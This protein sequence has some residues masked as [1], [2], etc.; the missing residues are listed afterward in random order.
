MSET[1]PAE[2]MIDR[3]VR[4]RTELAE[5]NFADRKAAFRTLLAAHVDSSAF[6]TFEGHLTDLVKA[7]SAALPDFVLVVRAA[8]H[9]RDAVIAGRAWWRALRQRESDRDQ[10]VLAVLPETTLWRMREIG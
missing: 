6:A 8:R 9:E 1:P 3:Q 7:I 2:S 10:A 5:R 4:L